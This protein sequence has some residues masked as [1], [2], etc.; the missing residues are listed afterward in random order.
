[1]REYAKERGFAS[2]GKPDSEDICFVP[3]GDYAAFLDRESGRVYPEGDFV[4]EDG[5]IL[6]RHR[7][8]IH[9]TVGQ[10]KG[11]GIS[12]GQRMFVRELR[13]SDNAVVLTADSGVPCHSLIAS[14][15]TFTGGTPAAPM[16]CTAVVRYQGKE[17]PAAVTP[18]D[19]GRARVDFHISA[20]AACPGQAVVLYRDDI[21]LGG[22][23]IE[24]VI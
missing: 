8:L 4:D 23:V 6:G 3:D 1:V 9:Y 22:G 24:R 5:N 21:V 11:L 15:F 20:R 14:D 12:C 17:Y 19:D 18:M 7:G 16:D 10:R 2:A 13:P